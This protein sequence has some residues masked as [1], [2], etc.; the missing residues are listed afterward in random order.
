MF[1]SKDGR[2][3][4]CRC[5]RG[6]AFPFRGTAGGTARSEGGST[7]ISNPHFRG[8][9][10]AMELVVRASLTFR[11]V[12]AQGMA[13]AVR[14]MRRCPLGRTRRSRGG[15]TSISNLLLANFSVGLGQGME[16]V[17]RALLVCPFL[18][19]GREWSWQYE[20]Y[21]PPLSWD[22]AGNR[23]GGS[24]IANLPLLGTGQGAWSWWYE[25]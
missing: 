12:G 25:H 6:G 8:T 19:L 10:Q 22:R 2:E 3:W 11:W 16:L 15:N 17:V 24:N 20:H 7:I 5:E 14:A 1:P 21:Y 9:G 18:R 4:S 23:A 13:V